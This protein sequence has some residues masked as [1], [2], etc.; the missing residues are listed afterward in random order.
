LNPI[1]PYIAIDEELELNLVIAM[2]ILSRLSRTSKGRSVLNFERLQCYA[3]LIKNPIRIGQVLRVAGKKDLALESRYTHTIESLSVNVDILFDRKKLKSLLLKLAGL[4]FL[5][6]GSSEGDSLT[7][8]L[9]ESGNSFMAEFFYS[10]NSANGY[11]SSLVEFSHKISPLN[12]LS[13]SKLNSILNITF[14]GE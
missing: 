7:Y 8:E 12:S 6:C 14:K 11:A 13:V 1:L 2:V 3:Y 5:H 10:D 9:S 4:G